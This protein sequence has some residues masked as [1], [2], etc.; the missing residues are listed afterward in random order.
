MQ[1]RSFDVPPI[2]INNKSSREAI[3]RNNYFNVNDDPLNQYLI[4]FGSKA[5]KHTI[6]IFYSMECGLSREFIRKDLVELLRLHLDN[7]LVNYILYPVGLDHLTACFMDAIKPLS[8]QK[9]QALLFQY[10]KHTSDDADT[11][12]FA[13]CLYES[14]FFD[15]TKILTYHPDITETLLI[16]VNGTL[17]REVPSTYAI[18][19]YLRTL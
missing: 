12:Q 11:P 15:I 6:E 9:K 10:S 18:E 19:L 7:I 2:I 1:Y 13:A 17:L 8:V 16:K 5:A 14:I 3:L 4:S